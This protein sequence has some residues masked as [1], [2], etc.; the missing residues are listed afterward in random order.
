MKF[1]NEHSFLGGG[2]KQIVLR[3]S[4]L[5]EGEKK[6]EKDRQENGLSDHFER[7]ETYT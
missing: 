7:Q 5:F 4:L 3:C 1:E 2:V 6:E